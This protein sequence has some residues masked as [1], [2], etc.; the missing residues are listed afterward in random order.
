MVYWLSLLAGALELP[1]LNGTTRDAPAFIC[2]A[3][4]GRGSLYAHVKKEWKDMDNRVPANHARLWRFGI[5]QLR[6]VT[7]QLAKGERQRLTDLAEIVLSEYES[8]GNLH[9]SMERSSP[10]SHP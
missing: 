6:K 10:E 5:S 1:A 7:N 9:H 8:V 4:I 3:T 2:N